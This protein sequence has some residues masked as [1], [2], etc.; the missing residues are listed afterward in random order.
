[1]ML[2]QDIEKILTDSGIEPNEAKVE[3]RLLIEHFAG[4]IDIKRVECHIFRYVKLV[5]KYAVCMFFILVDK[6]SRQKCLSLQR[7]SKTSRTS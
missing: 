3:V 7:L 5:K 1:M 6:G 4:Y 2:I